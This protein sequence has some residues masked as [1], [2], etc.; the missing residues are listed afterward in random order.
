MINSILTWLAGLVIKYLLGRLEQAI[1]DHA[2]EL[3]RDAERDI[4][5]EANLKKFEEAKDHAARVKAASD[6]LNRTA[7]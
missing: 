7:P 2:A 1:I 5:N 3:K 4:V 6:L